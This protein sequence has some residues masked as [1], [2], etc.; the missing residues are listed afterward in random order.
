MSTSA[1]PQM[2]EYVVSLRGVD[3]RGAEGCVLQQL[4]K[5]SDGK[6]E[7]GELRGYRIW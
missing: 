5:C 6:Q 2:R 3:G 4:P 7:V 1:G